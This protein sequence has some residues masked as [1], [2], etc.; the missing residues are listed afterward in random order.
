MLNRRHLRIKV[1][2]ALYAWNQSS[3]KDIVRFEKDFLKSL[4]KINEL[5]ILLLLFIVELRDYANDHIENSKH[6]KLPTQNDL[7]PNT[8]FIDNLFIS[9]LVEDTRLMVLGSEFKL[10]FSDNRDMIKNIF[11]EISK[12]EEFIYYM[13]ISDQNFNDDKKF[14]LKIFSKQMV[15]AELFQ[16]YLRDLNIYWEDDLPFITSMITKNIKDSDQDN[17]S[18]LSLFKDKEEEKFAINLFRKA[19]TNSDRFSELISVKVNNWEIERVAQMDLILM[20]MALTELIEMPTVP[21][22][23]SMNEYIDLAKYYST[24]RSKKFVNGILDNLVNELIK[25]GTIKKTGRGLIE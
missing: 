12:S 5:Y 2:Q 4:D 15:E 6:K 3:D 22:K 10:S 20:Q 9:K 25:D 7:T 11:L 21:V 8:K 23:V 14:I 19:I 24:E 1:L 18:L 13:S 16:D 17:I